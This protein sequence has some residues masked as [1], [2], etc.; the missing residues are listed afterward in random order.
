MWKWVEQKP[1]CVLN[2]THLARK[3]AG[4]HGNVHTHQLISQV[5]EFG[6]IGNE[7]VER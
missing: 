7:K 6:T 5:K 2:K 3:D 4:F 1:C